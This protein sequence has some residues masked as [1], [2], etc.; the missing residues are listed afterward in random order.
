MSSAFEHCARGNAVQLRCAAE[1]R[2]LHSC[3]YLQVLDGATAALFLI[4][5]RAGVSSADSDVADWLRRHH[6]ALPVRVVAAKCD[7]LGSSQLLSNTLEAASLGF[8]DAVPFSAESQEGTADLY[9]ALRPLVDTA[10]QHASADARGT[11]Q[12]DQVHHS[13]EDPHDESSAP[14][15]QHNRASRAAMRTADAF[16]GWRAHVERPAPTQLESDTGDEDQSEWLLEGTPDTQHAKGLAAQPAASASNVDPS[17]PDKS[18]VLGTDVPIKLAIVGLPNVGKSTLL[19]HL[20]G[21]E[22]ALTGPEPGLTRDAVAAPFEFEGKQFE[23]VDTAG[24]MRHA[25]L[26]RY[27]EADG[28]VAGLTVVQV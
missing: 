14:G 21:Y 8:G 3:D 17:S 5:A 20:V 19:N 28:R 7:N 4:D 25:T 27:D 13:S 2:S 6:S 1:R 24:W 26:Q 11:Q 10:E 12:S 23:L 22:R 15:V 9:D 18:A 16:G